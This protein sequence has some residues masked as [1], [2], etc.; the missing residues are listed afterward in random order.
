VKGSLSESAFVLVD[1]GLATFDPQRVV[2]EPGGVRGSRPTLQ[3]VGESDGRSLSG[4]LDGVWFPGASPGSYLGAQGTVS[5]S[6]NARSA[7]GLFNGNL[8]NG[9][10]A[11]NFYGFCPAADHAWLIIPVQ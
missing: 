2:L 11:L 3:F 7:N 4:R 6:R 1:D 10:Y 5:G 9:T 8:F